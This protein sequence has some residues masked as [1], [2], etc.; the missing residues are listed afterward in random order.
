[1]PYKV[2][3]GKGKRPF[4]IIAGNGRQVGSSTTKA[5]AQASARI[6][7]QRG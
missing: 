1:M 6:R 7:S 2:K 5:K 3:R 4:K